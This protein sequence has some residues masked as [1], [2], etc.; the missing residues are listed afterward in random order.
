VLHSR[1]D[2]LLLTSSKVFWLHGKSST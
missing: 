2:I 1:C